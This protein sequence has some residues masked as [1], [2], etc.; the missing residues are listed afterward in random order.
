MAVGTR[1]FKK[2]EG[3]FWRYISRVSPM[4]HISDRL[5]ESGWVWFYSAEQYS[6]NDCFEKILSDLEY[7]EYKKKNECQ[8]QVI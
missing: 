4:W 7:I 2:R 6:L 1:R 8:D 5:D 3:L